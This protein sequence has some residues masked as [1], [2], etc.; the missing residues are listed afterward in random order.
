MNPWLYIVKLSYSECPNYV[1]W[2]AQKEKT[3]K[4]LFDQPPQDESASRQLTLEK[5]IMNTVGDI[6]MGLGIEYFNSRLI[7]SLEE[8]GLLYLG[9]AFNIN[10]QLTGDSIIRVP[11]GFDIREIVRATRANRREYYYRDEKYVTHWHIHYDLSRIRVTTKWVTYMKKAT[12]HFR[13]R[14]FYFPAF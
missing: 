9:D 14:G 5:L 4:P 10:D 2:F 6:E 12:D 8:N 11:R 7:G 3:D 13:K 1:F